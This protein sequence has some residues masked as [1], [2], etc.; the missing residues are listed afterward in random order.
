MIELTEKQKR[1]LRTFCYYCKGYGTDE[2]SRYAGVYDCNIEQVETVWR[3]K[4]GGAPIESYAQVEDIINDIIYDEDVEN[5]VRDLFDCTETNGDLKIEIDLKE[6]KIYG[7]LSYNELSTNSEGDEKELGDVS[8]KYIDSVNQVFEYMKDN[9][10]DE[11]KLTY[12][13]S[14]DSGDIDNTFYYEGD[15]ID[16]D[17]T[18]NLLDFCYDWLSDSF[19]GWEINEGSQGSIIF[20]LDNQTI[21]IHHDQNYY[22]NV[23]AGQIF[24]L[25][26]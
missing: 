3:K 1:T 19:G 7:R 24:Y 25:E 23:D 8:N 18:D 22:D 20:Y 6:Y 16:F 4:G 9:D 10:Y 5:H 14:G 11:L 17:V 2:V 12:N 21:Q 26:F 15:S 13:G